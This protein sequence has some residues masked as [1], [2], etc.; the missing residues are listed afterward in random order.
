[1]IYVIDMS[2]GTSIRGAQSSGAF[3][4]RHKN[5]G[6]PTPQAGKRSCVGC[7]NGGVTAGDGLG[8]HQG[9]LRGHFA[10][11]LGWFHVP[12]HMQ[13]HVRVHHL[14]LRHASLRRW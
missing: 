13:D 10:A 11:S 2:A 14:R 6:S 3:P 4:E 5:S 12:E 7:D 9:G 8:H 1:M